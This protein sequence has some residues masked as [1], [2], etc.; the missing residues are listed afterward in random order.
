MGETLRPARP[1]EAPALAWAALEASRGHTGRGTWDLLLPGEDDASRIELIESVLLSDSA[2]PCHWAGFRVLERDGE[3]VS[4]LAAYDPGAP[5]HLPLGAVLA[6]AFEEL[7][8]TGDELAA[9][10][11]RLA[12]YDT[13][14]PE[15]RA[16]SWI[17]EWVATRPGAR[18]T[19]CAG[20]LIEDALAVG[21]ERGLAR[22]QISLGIGNDA[23]RRSYE[24]LGFRV[25]RE[26]R[27][28]DFERAMLAPGMLQMAREL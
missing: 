25:E 17:L 21:R 15:S 8:Y 5:G 1:D 9:A 24:R 20:R 13:C 26:R 27:H 11:Q 10:F 19:G 4:L 18:G 16:G 12:E 23:A 6:E 7:G 3:P 2:S 14:A 22:A 28:P